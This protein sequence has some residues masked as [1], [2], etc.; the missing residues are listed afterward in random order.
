MIRNVYSG[1]GI[2]VL[3]LAITTCGHKEDSATGSEQSKV[4]EAVE[5]AVT[6]ELKLYEGAKQSLKDIERQAEERRKKEE[7]A[8]SN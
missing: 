8:L 1:I 6:R 4:K 3:A 2:L 7:Q 5:K